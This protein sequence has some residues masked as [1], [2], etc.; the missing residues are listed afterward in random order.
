MCQSPPCPLQVDVQ[1]PLLRKMYRRDQTYTRQNNVD[2][3][4]LRED[5]RHKQTIHIGHEQNYENGTVTSLPVNGNFP[6]VPPNPRKRNKTY[7]GGSFILCHVQI[8]H[9]VI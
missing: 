4:F 2:T 8:Y 5:G 7:A 1:F 3:A 9:N 6:L